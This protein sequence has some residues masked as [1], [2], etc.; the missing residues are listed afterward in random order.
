MQEP[1]CLIGW[2]ISG[3]VGPHTGEIGIEIYPSF[4]S[5]NFTKLTHFT[6]H[7]YCYSLFTTVMADVILEIGLPVGPT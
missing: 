6:I 7:Y 2:S 1:R 3:T 4:R 5:T